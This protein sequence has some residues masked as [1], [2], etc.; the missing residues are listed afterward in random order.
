MKKQG[1]LIIQ[2]SASVERTH[3]ILVMVADSAIK[4]GHF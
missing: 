1:T 2:A 3:G 4:K